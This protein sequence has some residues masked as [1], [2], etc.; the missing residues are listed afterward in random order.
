[1]AATTI[2]RPSLTDDDGSGTT[3]GIL[4]S[5]NLGLWIFDKIDALFTASLRQEASTSGAIEYTIQNTHTGTGAYAS[6]N[7]GNSASYYRSQVV[8][9]STGYTTSGASKADGLKVVSA[10]A[11]GLELQATAAGSTVAVSTGSITDAVAVAQDGHVVL[12]ELTANPGTAVLAADAALALYT[13]A[14]KLCFAYNN[15]GTMTY[16]TL[17]LDGTSTTWSH[18]TTAP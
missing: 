13:K 15:S 10:G 3:G 16:L 2:T 12:A 17:A 6:I 7:I 9:F 5:T 1:M 11:G 8:Q 14:D 18:S 4:N